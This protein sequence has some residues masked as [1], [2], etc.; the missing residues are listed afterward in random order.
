VGVILKNKSFLIVFLIILSLLTAC[1]DDVVIEKT[2]KTAEWNKKQIDLGIKHSALMDWEDT[3][4]DSIT[5]KAQ[6]QMQSKV[7]LFKNHNLEDAYEKDG[8]LF[9][10]FD[11]YDGF[12]LI[13]NTSI[14]STLAQK[15]T[16]NDLSY[17]DMGVIAKVNKVSVPL[18]KLD[19]QIEDGNYI[20]VEVSTGTIKMVYGELLD[21]VIEE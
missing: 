3:L 10:K 18:I 7:V 13:L 4:V 8:S 16:S 20:E 19:P 12:Y 9:L 6:Q 14:D 1:S 21:I 15:L 17:K 5:L 2:D 11:G